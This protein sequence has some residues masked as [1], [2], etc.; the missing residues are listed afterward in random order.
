[1]SLGIPADAPNIEGYLFPATYTFDPGVD[2][3]TVL[4]V[5]VNRTFQSLD[6]AGVAPEDRAGILTIASLIQREAGVNRDDFYK[7]SRVIQNR[8]DKGMQ[9]Q[10][11]STSHY[12]YVWAH[13]DREDGGGVFSSKAE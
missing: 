12:G 7:V 13:G 1:P 5:L 6:A 10:F 8:L 3:K 2:A 4:Q 11:D 9:L